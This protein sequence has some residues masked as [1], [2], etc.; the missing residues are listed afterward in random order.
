MSKPTPGAGGAYRYDPET[1]RYV[2]LE[3]TADDLAHAHPLAS[4]VPEP[5]VMSGA[6]GPT[7]AKS[8][9]TVTKPTE[10]PV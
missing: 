1:D 7:P 5:P 9:P 3:A 4:T 8:K 6:E 10:E 2:L